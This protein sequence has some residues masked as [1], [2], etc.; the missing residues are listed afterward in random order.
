MKNKYK[1]DFFDRLVS[2]T[3]RPERASL[4]ET[5]YVTQL[6]EMASNERQR[7]VE[8]INHAIFKLKKEQ[9]VRLH[10]RNYHAVLKI[11]LE[12]CEGYEEDPV[13]NSAPA[14]HELLKRV[15]S[16]L[17]ALLDFVHHRFAYYLSSGDFPGPTPAY[18]ESK[19]IKK[20]S[21]RLSVDQ[22]ALIFRAAFDEEIIATP[23]MASLYRWVVPFLS[24][25]SKTDIS[26]NSMRSKAYA[27]ETADK[28][29]SIAIL[30]RLINAIRNY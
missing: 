14:L 27:A 28:N 19:E 23:S 12:L 11:L 18:Q 10:I 5:N 8:H 17:L 16:H 20:I 1:L 22:L 3:M 2:V 15:R 21:C 29:A 6:L 13:Y 26:Y 9:A 24:T 30:Q 7:T 25:T 4:F